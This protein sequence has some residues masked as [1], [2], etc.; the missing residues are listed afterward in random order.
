MSFVESLDSLKKIFL[1][2]TFLEPGI[3]GF[4]SPGCVPGLLFFQESIYSWDSVSWNLAIPGYAAI[5][6]IHTF[7][8]WDV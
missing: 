4:H 7:C 5:H 1:K 2:A 3:I 6:R 8:C